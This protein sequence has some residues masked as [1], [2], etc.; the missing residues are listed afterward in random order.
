MSG[1]SEGA[2]PDLTPMLDMVFQLITFF[3]LVMNMK[4]AALDQS[5][6]L[7]VVGSARPV[8][9]KGKEELLILNVTDD[10][11]LNTYGIKRDPGPYI[12]SEAQVSR[13]AAKQN[14]QTIEPGGELP[15]RVVIRCDR[16]TPFKTLYAVIQLC[17]D[18]GFVDFA[19][20]AMERED[21]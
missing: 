8:D 15:T 14:G 21:G 7:P 16:N 17:Q 20:R 3:M 19:L 18:E 6:K 4:A 9:T 11:K 12:K 2:E 10:G 5:L 13:I 1:S